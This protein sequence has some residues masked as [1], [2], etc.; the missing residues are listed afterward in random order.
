MKCWCVHPARGGGA[1]ATPLSRPF[2]PAILRSPLQHHALLL[3]PLPPPTAS[4]GSW[5]EQAPVACRSCGTKVGVQTWVA[6]RTA[7]AWRR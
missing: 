7:S 2:A 3:L 4:P 1:M 5:D 6:R